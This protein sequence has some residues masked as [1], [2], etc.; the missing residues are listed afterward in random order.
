MKFLYKGKDGGPQSP[1][2]GYWL[3]EWKAGF[4]IVLLKFNKGMRTAYHSHAFHAWTWWL[5]GEAEE[6]HVDG[7][8][9]HWKPS[10]FPK[11]TPRDCF[12]RFKVRKTTWAFCVRGLWAKT[13]Q[14]YE[15]GQYRTLTNGRKLVE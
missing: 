11:W 15:D 12:H 2:T 14:E 10:P 5:K 7:R 1:V 8:T 3:I 9:L 4:S 6:Q 13:W